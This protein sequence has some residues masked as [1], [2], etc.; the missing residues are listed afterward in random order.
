MAER[1]SRPRA[2][3]VEEGV[4]GR[5]E[6]VCAYMCVLVVVGRVVGVAPVSALSL[7]VLSEVGVAASRVVGLSCQPASRSESTAVGSAAIV[8]RWC[9]GDVLLCFAGEQLARRRR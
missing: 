8:V 3:A 2:E 6:K 1:E 9:G 4:E 7:P 5:V